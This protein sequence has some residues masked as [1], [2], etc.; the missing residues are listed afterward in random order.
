MGKNPRLEKE[1]DYNIKRRKGIGTGH[2]EV[3]T[4]C[5]YRIPDEIDVQEGMTIP[6][7]VYHI[8]CVRCGW[9]IAKSIIGPQGLCVKCM[10]LSERR[11][12]NRRNGRLV[13]GEIDGST[14]I[15]DY[16]LNGRM[17]MHGDEEEMLNKRRKDDRERNDVKNT[18]HEDESCNQKMESSSLID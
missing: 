10:D 8:R 11:K 1:P 3:C 2:L 14:D 9:P 4:S 16:P 12:Y 18:T 17:Y 15:K 7:S 6:C 5:G 13:Y